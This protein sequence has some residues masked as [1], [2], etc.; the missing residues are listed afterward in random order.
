MTDLDERITSALR[1]RAEG[2]IDTG[3]LLR[4]S[5]VRGRRRQMR[6]RAATGTALALV[7]VLGFVGVT[8]ADLGGLPGRLPWTA[9]TPSAAPPVPPRADGVPGAAQRP[10]LVGTDPQALHLGV[11]PSQARYL[12]WAVHG[13]QV[14]SIRFSVGS[15][16]PV[17]VEV[18]PS[19]QAVNEFLIDGVPIDEAVIPLTFDGAVRQIRGGAGLIKAW[20][21]VPGLYAR[22][23]MLGGDR[24]ALDR[25]VDAVRWDEARRCASPL[26]LTTLPEGTTVTACSVDATAFPT[27]LNVELTLSRKEPSA[28]MRVLLLYG[29]QIAANR[30]QSNRT[31]GGRPAYLSP[32]GTKLDLLGIPKAHLTA[33]FGWPWPGDAPPK[34]YRSFTEADASTVLAGAQVAKVL[35]DP[36]TWE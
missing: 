13:P 26:R 7:G 32:D 29:A 28:T 19:A 17:L 5:R 24:A 8:G 16:Q 9:A 18:S 22:A 30:D 2:E 36:E 35:T 33:E 25:A 3:R 11:D 15:G 1:E 10:D 21:P 20:Q 27:G 4:A 12:R 6:R 23:S 31:V 34:G 14:E